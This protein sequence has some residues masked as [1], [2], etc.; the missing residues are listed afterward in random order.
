MPTM[1]FPAVAVIVCFVLL[2]PL[3]SAQAQQSNTLEW[4]NFGNDFYSK[5]WHEDN[6]NGTLQRNWS[7]ASGPI[8]SYLAKWNIQR[9][10]LIPDISRNYRDAKN[11]WVRVVSFPNDCTISWTGT[12]SVEPRRSHYTFGLKTSIGPFNHWEPYQKGTRECYIVQHS[13]RPVSYYDD[14]KDF[15]YVGTLT[16]AGSGVGYRCYRA[17]ANWNPAEG[18]FWQLWAFRENNIW[19]GSVP[20]QEFVKFW[21]EKTGLINYD[22]DY[23]GWWSIMCEVFETKGEYELTEVQFPKV[24]IT[25]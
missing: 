8:T 3:F 1:R 21:S 9:G 13:N 4:L 22:T 7:P 15:H 12:A 6:T 11:N 23:I 24:D 16:P 20:V 25:E 10:N 19:S 14:Q 18:G 17:W 5:C 2:F